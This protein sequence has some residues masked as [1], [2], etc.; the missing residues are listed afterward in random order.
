MMR[1]ISN[2]VK[3]CYLGF[4]FQ[5]ELDRSITTEYQ[6]E[7]DKLHGDRDIKFKNVNIYI[8]KM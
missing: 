1:G 6:N 4:F 7:N 2:W 8:T 3:L 5:S